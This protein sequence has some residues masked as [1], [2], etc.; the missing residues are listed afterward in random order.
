[1]G[2]CLKKKKSS[3]VIPPEYFITC[4]CKNIQICDCCYKCTNPNCDCFNLRKCQ[5]CQRLMMKEEFINYFGYC[6]YCRGTM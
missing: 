1:M 6:E 5:R 2:N 3:D 4:Q